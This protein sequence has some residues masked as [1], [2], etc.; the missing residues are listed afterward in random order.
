MTLVDATQDLL[1]DLGGGLWEEA[2]PSTS[3]WDSFLLGDMVDW[4]AV[5]NSYSMPEPG[6]T[7]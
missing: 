3:E 7:G 2:A 6:Y 5:F 4:T 1:Q